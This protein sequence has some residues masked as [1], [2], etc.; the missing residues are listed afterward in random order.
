MK[1]VS[2]CP[3]IT[4]LV[5]DLGAGDRLL[6]VTKFCIHPAAEVASLEKVGGTKDPKLDRIRELKPDLILM[7][8]EENRREDWEALTEAGLDCHISHPCS[9]DASMAFVADLGHRLGRAAAA[10]AL[11]EEMKRAR[12]R[13]RVARTGAGERSF[14]YLIW[15]KPWMTIN[16]STYISSL[17]AEAGAR[18]VFGDHPTIYPAVSAEELASVDPDLVLL[19]SEPFPFKAKHIDELAQATGMTRERFRLVD[20]ELLSWHGALT[21]AGLDYLVEVFAD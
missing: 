4:K 11:I 15:R 8:R 20:G 13:L 19:S 18:N 2:L 5:F 16:G 1:L 14:A 10:A 3:S 7:N 17:I 21:A 6:A 12:T 9:V